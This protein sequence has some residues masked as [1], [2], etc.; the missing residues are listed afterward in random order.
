MPQPMSTPTAAGMMAPL[1]G[2]TDPTV[3]PMPTWASGMS[4]MCPDTNGRSAALL[5]CSKV[6]S[7]IS[8]AHDTTLPRRVGDT[9]SSYFLPLLA[10]G[11]SV[12]RTA[13]PSRGTSG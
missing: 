5:A 8:D 1:V 4:A 12:A 2:M 6:A 10:C 3:D 7:S 9:T 11:G 13:W